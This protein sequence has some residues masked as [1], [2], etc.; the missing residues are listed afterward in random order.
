ML[1]GLLVAAG[2]RIVPVDAL[3]DLVNIGT[4]LAFVIVCLA[5]LIMRHSNPDLRRPFRCPFVPVV[6]IAGDRSVI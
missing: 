4:L 6:P 5:V 1:T 3:A 2:R